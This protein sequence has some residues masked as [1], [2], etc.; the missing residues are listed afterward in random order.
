MQI[1]KD[2]VV[3]LSTAKQQQMICYRTVKLERETNCAVSFETGLLV[4]FMRCTFQ[5]SGFNVMH[6]TAEQDTGAHLQ[7]DE[8]QLTARIQG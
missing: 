2:A 1:S 7:L 8:M 3:C 6:K 4:K 5:C